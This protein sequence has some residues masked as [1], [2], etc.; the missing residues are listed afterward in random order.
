MNTHAIN[1]NSVSKCTAVYIG[2]MEYNKSLALQRQ[3][4][5]EIVDGARAN[6]L[7]LVEHPHVYTLGRR[8]SPSEAS[9]R[10][11][12]HPYAS[13]PVLSVD[14]GGQAT[15]HGPGQI[16]CYPIVRLRP[17]FDGPLAFVRALE[18]GVA[19]TLASFGITVSQEP[20]PTG[21]WTGGAK[22][23]AIGLRVSRGVTTHGVA[24]NVEPDLSYFDHIVQC[25]DPN[26]QATS[27]AAELGRPVSVADVVGPLA[28]ALAAAFG[29]R[30]T[31]E[32]SEPQH[33]AGASVSP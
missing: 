12:P 20:R 4:A 23:A 32:S 19:A 28:E 13:V 2:M 5:K 24:L 27:M 25:G 1:G 21:V 29:W 33:T 16:V 30:L 7:M 15:Y 17:T 11:G 31:W 3:L 8:A 22:I 18:A 14:R 6:T 10:E 26:A 9:V